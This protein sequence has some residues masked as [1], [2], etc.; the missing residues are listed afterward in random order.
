MFN[1]KIYLFLYFVTCEC[2]VHTI[3]KQD[4]GFFFSS[5]H[6]RKLL[7]LSYKISIKKIKVFHVKANTLWNILY[8]TIKGKFRSFIDGNCKIPAKLCLIFSFNSSN[9]QVY[10]SVPHKEWHICVNLSNNF[11]ECLFSFKNMYR[12]IWFIEP[13]EKLL[14]ENMSDY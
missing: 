5:M 11:V 9:F 8:V 12:L 4:G 6:Y 14:V 1:G 7:L 10:P 2:V 3:T 13:L